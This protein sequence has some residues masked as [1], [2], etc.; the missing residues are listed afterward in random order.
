MKDQLRKG[1]E[2][3]SEKE[4]GAKVEDRRQRSE[5]IDKEIEREKCVVENVDA[6]VIADSVDAEEED[7]DKCDEI[8]GLLRKSI[9]EMNEREIRERAK[10]VRDL[11]REIAEKI[12][13]KV[14]ESCEVKSHI[15]EPHPLGSNLDKSKE[16]V[17]VNPFDVDRTEKDSGFKV[18]DAIEQT[19]SIK[20]HSVTSFNI[21]EQD[22]HDLDNDQLTETI[23]GNVK[24][25]TI[26]D[27]ASSKVGQKVNE[28]ANVPKLEKKGP[29]IANV[30][31]KAN[32]P[33]VEKKGP[34]ITNIVDKAN[35]PTKSKIGRNKRK[36]SDALDYDA[37]MNESPTTN[38]SENVKT[39]LDNTGKTPL[40]SSTSTNLD[41]LENDNIN[42]P[43]K[44]SNRNKRKLAES[45]DYD[46]MISEVG[47][48]F[49]ALDKENITEE[50]KEETVGES[51]ERQAELKVKDDT[52]VSN[53][54]GKTVGPSNSESD[55]IVID[56]Q[57]NANQV[58]SDNQP[59]KSNSKVDQAE[60]GNENKKVLGKDIGDKTE[61][62]SIKKESVDSKELEDDD[63]DD[64]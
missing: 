25:V 47:Q 4:S 7:K 62:K 35:V 10:E 2:K 8:R 52:I 57:T 42:R 13:E 39:Q 18:D 49:V 20:P 58:T 44:S 16:I 43:T 46:E 53:E 29:T 9:E 15:S 33:K 5:R 55:K 27:T 45:L 38:L 36:L 40:F 6:I 19:V 3:M 17:Y 1:R 54:T 30:V 31:E 12:R 23:V 21:K 41:R 28:K 22:I 60:A 26:I 63:D 14:R 11:T 34:T 51:N 50:T 32:V 64:V 24:H 59:F 48:Q 56:R 61:T 37:M